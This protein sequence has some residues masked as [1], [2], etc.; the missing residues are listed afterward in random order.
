MTLEYTVDLIPQLLCSP[1]IVL[2]HQLTMS[3]EIAGISFIDFLIMEG[4]K[5]LLFSFTWLGRLDTALS[6]LLNWELVEVF[7][8]W[9]NCSLFQAGGRVILLPPKDPPRRP[10]SNLQCRVSQEFSICSF[11]P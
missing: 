6:W 1:A 11:N 5:M 9:A 8:G 3:M 10:L 7:L 2:H 4:W